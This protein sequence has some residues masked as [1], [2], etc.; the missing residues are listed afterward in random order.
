MGTIMNPSPGGSSGT[1][2]PRARNDAVVNLAGGSTLWPRAS[3]AALAI[4]YL[5]GGAAL[6]FG[7]SLMGAH[8]PFSSSVK[9]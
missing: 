8:P 3:S 6:F 1:L 9:W 2:K 4:G 7:S 5:L